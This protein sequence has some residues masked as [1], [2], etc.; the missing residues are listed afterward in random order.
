MAKYPVDFAVRLSKAV[1]TSSRAL[2]KEN[3]DQALAWRDLLRSERAWPL[4]VLLAMWYVLQ[5][6]REPAYRAAIHNLADD[7]LANTPAADFYGIWRYFDAYKVLLSRAA[8]LAYEAKTPLELTSA[9]GAFKY[10]AQQIGV[11]QL[12]AALKSRLFIAV[13]D[14]VRQAVPAPDGVVSS[15]DAGRAVR[16]ET[17]VASSAQPT[18]RALPVAPDLSA[19]DRCVLLLVSRGH[20]PAEAEQICKG[21]ERVAS[22]VR[23]QGKGRIA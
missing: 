17:A 3:E 23:P 6:G 20:S 4:S 16:P 2:A 15:L 8:Q 5:T 12:D 11:T 21:P 9:G 14:M 18:P 19:Q 7:A 13:S 22:K 1:A 10:A